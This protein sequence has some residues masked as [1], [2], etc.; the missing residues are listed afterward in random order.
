MKI[1]T[2]A[3]I[4]GGVGKTTLAFNFAEYLAYKK[5]K[6][7]LLID[8]DHQCNL[9]QT[10]DIYNTDNTVGEIFQGNS[11]KVKLFDVA[12][13]ISI[14]PGNMHLDNIEHSIENDTN[15]NM[16]M[17]L[18]LAD[19]YENLNLGS[20]DYIILDTHPDFG[21]A[22]KNAFAISHIA[23]SPITP[24]KD[25]YNAKFNLKERLDE[26]RKEAIDFN[27]RKSYVTA[28]LLYIANMIKNNTHSSKELLNA[29]KD[30]PEVVASVPNKEAFNQSTLAK[31]SI[32]HAS[33]LSEEDVKNPDQKRL[34]NKLSRS[35]Q[36][37][38]LINIFNTFDKLQQIVDSAN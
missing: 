35:D 8:L 1:V 16:L 33:I 31:L 25:G 14:I 23:F 32:A 4:K 24:S 21:V 17:Y 3:A 36:R 5:A 29:I 20:Y 37:K 7:I 27:T 12:S 28:Q 30:D 22:T 13:N 15:K 10:Y 11:E 34:V 26:F 18:W 19:Q 38:F 6:K 9:T 2:F